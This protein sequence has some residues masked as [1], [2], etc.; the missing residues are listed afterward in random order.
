M[1]ALSETRQV[2]IL[3]YHSLTERAQ[4]RFR[5]FALAPALFTE[6]MTYLAQQGYTTLTISQYVSARK[7][8]VALPESVVALTF[9]DGFADF[10]SEALPVLQQHGFVATLYI[11]TAFVG[12]TSRFLRR[13]DETARPMLTWSQL[14]EIAAHR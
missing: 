13:E 2:P 5:K 10:Y 8:G 3:M 4:P 7:T 6:Q 14:I 12:N 1:V 9:D 11:A